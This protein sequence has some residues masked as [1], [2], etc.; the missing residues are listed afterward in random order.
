MLLQDFLHG[1]QHDA[2]AAAAEE[3]IRL[4]VNQI[5]AGVGQ[6]GERFQIVAAI[7]D[8][9]VEEGGGFGGLGGGA[10]VLASRRAPRLFAAR[11]DARPTGGTDLVGSF[12]A[13]KLFAMRGD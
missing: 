12:R 3:R 5:H 8:A 2:L 11:G 1:E 9:R 13:G 6:L 7:N 10:S 4:N